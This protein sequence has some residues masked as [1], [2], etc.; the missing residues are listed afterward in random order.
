MSAMTVMTMSVRAQMYQPKSDAAGT[1]R[2]G[3]G[4]SKTR[5]VTK[6]TKLALGTPKKVILLILG[7]PEDAKT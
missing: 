5:H 1:R 2:R 3:N 6:P 4:D 7:G